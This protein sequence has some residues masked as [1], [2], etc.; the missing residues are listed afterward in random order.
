MQRLAEARKGL[1]KNIDE[2]AQIENNLFNI[3][4]SLE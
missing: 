2:I 1:F 3:L 4:R